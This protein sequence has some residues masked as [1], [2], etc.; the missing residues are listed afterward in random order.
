MKEQA[1][2]PVFKISSHEAEVTLERNPPFR[3]LVVR[4]EKNPPGYIIP[5]K[6]FLMHFIAH[7]LFPENFPEPI[8]PSKFTADQPLVT[9]F[10]RTMR[11]H[12]EAVQ[13]F[14]RS[15]S[16]SNPKVRKYVLLIEQKRSEIQEATQKI[17]EAGIKVSTTIPNIG[18]RAN[19]KQTP[20]FF[21]IEEINL[22]KL[23]RKIESEKI[24][25]EKL[26]KAIER[27]KELP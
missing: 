12:R 9:K 11:A 19:K 15:R 3:G 16:L 4:R 20:V 18:L 14:Y 25:D 24:S 13:E 2:P 21:E 27:L 7:A 1:K 6:R 22:F 23:R 26:M 10:V 17:G 8:E 5:E